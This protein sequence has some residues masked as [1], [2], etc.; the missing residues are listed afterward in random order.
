MGLGLGAPDRFRSGRWP[1]RVARRHVYNVGTSCLQEPFWS[2]NT[3]T[4][5]WLFC[6]L[7]CLSCWRW[8]TCHVWSAPVASCPGWNTSV[9]ADAL[10][11]VTIRLAVSSRPVRNV[12]TRSPSRSCSDWI[13]LPRASDANEN[14]RRTVTR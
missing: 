3:V 13:T 7:R 14:C 4:L 9:A 2:P 1:G 11:V 6:W 10:N 5:S 8:C 12:A